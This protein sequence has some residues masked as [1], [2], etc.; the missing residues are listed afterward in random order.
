VRKLARSLTL[1]CALALAATWSGSAFAAYTPRLTVSQAS[2]KT[3]GGAVTFKVSQAE[4]DDPTANVT[5]YAPQGYSSKLDQ[6][7]GTRLGAA[8]GTVILKLLGGARRDITGAVRADSP[9]NYTT[10]AQLSTNAKACTGT[11]AHTAVWVLSLTLSGQPFDIPIY[12]DPVTAPPDTTFG[13]LKLQFCPL[14]PDVPAPIGAPSG[15]Q[16]VSATFT[17]NGVFSHPKASG[18]YPFKALFKPYLPGTATVNQVG[19]V[20]SQAIVALPVHLALIA[21]PATSSRVVLSGALTANQQGVGGAPIQLLAGRSA[22]RVKKI[23]TLRSNTR[24]R[25]RKVVKVTRTTY[26]RT[27]ATVRARNLGSSGCRPTLT[28][29]PCVSQTLAPFSVFNRGVI[30]IVVR[31]G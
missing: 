9:S 6:P 2:Q 17:V 11:A 23:A 7:S 8:R 25:Y 10:N 19:T 26:F 14:S 16:L 12:V 22:R 31:R 20:E 24:G 4:T 5:L 27:K 28:S 1:G 29:V 18:R 30:K 13:T 15:A 3:G 21:K